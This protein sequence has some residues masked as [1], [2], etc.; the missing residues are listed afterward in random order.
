MLEDT[1]EVQQ[2]PPSAAC[3]F[4]LFVWVPAALNAALPAALPVL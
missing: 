4:D 1:I 3:P 2:R